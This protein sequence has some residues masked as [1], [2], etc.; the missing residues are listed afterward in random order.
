MKSKAPR[1]PSGGPDVQDIEVEDPRTKPSS[2]IKAK[3]NVGKSS[4]EAPELETGRSKG[5]GPDVQEESVEDPRT[6]KTIAGAKKRFGSERGSWSEKPTDEIKVENPRT[7]QG[8]FYPKA[9]EEARIDRAVE[10]GYEPGKLGEKLS[11]ELAKELQGNARTVK[12]TKMARHM[13]DQGIDLD[14]VTPTKEFADS[15]ADGAG[16]PRSKARP[17]E[18]PMQTIKQAIEIARKLKPKEGL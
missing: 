12:A 15:V 11:P 4:G 2:R 10:R 8:Q 17:G 6:G 18:D 16:V 9:K 1:K 13:V 14:K 5:K 7:A 3:Y